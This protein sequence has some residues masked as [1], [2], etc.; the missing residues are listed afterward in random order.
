MKETKQKDVII[1]TRSA[2]V[3]AG[4]LHSFENN[5][6]VLKKAR[7]LWYW[8]GA[9]SLSQLSVHGVGNPTACKFPCEVE[10]VTLPE[11]I[12]ILPV[13][14]KARASIDAVKIWEV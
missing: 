14:P 4:L 7:R 10:E 8:S 3:F 2:G 11:V 5:T 1:R 9:A 13:T 6:A 12:E